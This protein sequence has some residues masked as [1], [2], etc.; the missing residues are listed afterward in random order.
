[1]RTPLLMT[2]LIAG[3]TLTVPSIAAP[4]DGASPIAGALARA[5]AEVNAIIEIP[6]DQ[7]TFKNTIWAMDDMLA[8]LEFSTSMTQFMP[9]V[10]TDADERAIGQAAT[11]ELQN[12]LI[13][14]QKDE[15]LYNAVKSFADTNP[16]LSGEDKRLLEHTM[17]DYRRAGMNLTSEQRDELAAVQKEIARLS[18]VFDENI[19]ED[20][21]RVLVSRADLDGCDPAWI[22]TLDTV[23]ELCIITMDYPTFWPTQ[24]YA[25]NEDT[26]ARVWYAYKRR[27]GTKNV[28]VIEEII[29]LRARAANIL[30]YAHPADYENEVR[31]SKSAD[32]IQAFYTQLRPLV[33]EKALQDLIEFEQ[34]KREHTGDRNATLQPWDFFYYQD[35]LMREKYAV[36]TT[37][38]KEYFPLDNVI[39]GLFSITQSLYGLKYIEVTDRASAM[40]MPIWHEDVRLFIVSDK[41]SGDELGMFYIDLHP[42]PF[43]YGHAA[44]WGL[45][46]HKMWS[47]GSIGKPLAALVCNFP[48]PIGDK[49]ALMS[50]DEVETFFHEFG[51]CLHTILSEANSYN[52]AGTSVERDFVEA[53]S[54]MFENWV[55]DRDVLRTFAAHYETGEPF[56]DDLLNGM[57]AAKNLGS[58]MLAERQFFYG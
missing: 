17:R 14:L 37:K 5:E 21:T 34:A 51:H 22:E 44:Q 47:D 46:Q 45:K 23:G 9:Y 43:K 12:W 25:N 31:M 3:A 53:P 1:M 52:F 35:Y 57:L 32:N 20:D 56:P 8:R 15:A 42:R 11:Q 2:T 13:D 41:A 36:D 24:K 29:S 18:I 6:D 27:A 39:D 40:D 50:H 48:K 19:R 33:R 28:K 16:V 58:G 55:W 10:S 4:Q 49:P 7:R 26:R 30:G 54:Q 38:V